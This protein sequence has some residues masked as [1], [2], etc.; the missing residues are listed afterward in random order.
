MKE[1]SEGSNYGLQG[2]YVEPLGVQNVIRFVES[3]LYL[4]IR[5]CWQ[6]L[7]RSPFVLRIYI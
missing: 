7:N 6:L 1:S 2:Q 4:S 5:T 3:G